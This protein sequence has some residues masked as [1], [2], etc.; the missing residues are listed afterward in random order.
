MAQDQNKSVPPIP[1]QVQI[2]DDRNYLNPVWSR[3]FVQL[4]QRIGGSLA[5]SNSELETIQTEGIDELE[6]QVTDLTNRVALLENSG[7]SF[8]VGPIL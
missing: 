2:V 6:A 8:G 1:L 7:L 5:L 4:Y 3:W